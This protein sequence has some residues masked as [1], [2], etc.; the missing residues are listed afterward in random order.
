MKSLFRF[1]QFIAQFVTLGLALAFVVTLLA[2]QWVARLRGAYPPP[3]NTGTLLQPTFGPAGPAAPASAGEEE[4]SPAAVAALPDENPTITRERARAADTIMA[5]YSR[6][7]Q[8]AAPSVVSI[9]ADKITSEQQMIVP[10]DPRLRQVIPPIPYGAP[11]R[12]AIHSLGSGV[13][14]D[15]KGYVLT[16]DHV[17]SGAEQIKAVLS[18]G[19]T[20]TV[21]LV[22]SD[23]DTDLA[24]LKLDMSNL[25]PLPVSDQVPAVGDVVLAIGSPFGLGNTVT[26][27]IISA[28]GRQVT[29]TSYE[30]SI[31]TDATINEGNSGGALVNAFGELVGINS[32]RYSPPGGGNVGISFAIPVSTAKSVLEQIIDHGRVIRGWMGAAYESLPPQHGNTESALP[33]GV[34]I[35]ALVA[36]G[37]AARAGLKPGD[38][39]TQFGGEPIVNQFD[40][41]NRE[42][43]FA[44]GSKVEVDALR[45]GK[46]IKV[47]VVLAEKPPLQNVPANGG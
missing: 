5:S 34:A 3:A 42:S 14:V 32:S 25:P 10:T 44:P 2:P 13:I 33:R 38:V 11:Y 8:R 36:D 47:D 35:S 7:V 21:K 39:L 22:G 31:Q 24:V 46:P 29:P 12:R 15:R 41:Y 1:L 23:A 26:M 40:L 30:D 43:H 28:L 20:A 6:A 17:I 19:R 9:T 18:D 4:E 37:P 27:G 16:N 45:G